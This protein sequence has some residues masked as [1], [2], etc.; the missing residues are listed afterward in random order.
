VKNLKAQEKFKR[1]P[2]AALV[3]GHTRLAKW[4]FAIGAF[5]VL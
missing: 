1:T 2:A 5:L 3:N 4:R